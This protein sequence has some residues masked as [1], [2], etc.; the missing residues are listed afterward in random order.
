MASVILFLFSLKEH[1]SINIIFRFSFS[2]FHFS[3]FIQQY[4]REKSHSKTYF[5]QFAHHEYNVTRTRF[6]FDI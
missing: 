6:T 4:I 5:Q 1:T 2:I 3:F